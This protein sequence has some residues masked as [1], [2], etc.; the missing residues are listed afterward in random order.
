M[1]SKQPAPLTSIDPPS[2]T[3]PGL[4]RGNLRNL[5]ATG[6]RHHPFSLRILVSPGVEYPI[7]VGKGMSDK[8]QFVVLGHERFLLRGGEK[9]RFVRHNEVWTIVSNPRIDRRYGGSGFSRRREGA[10]ARTELSVSSSSTRDSQSHLAPVPPSSREKPLDSRDPVGPRFR[11]L[12]PGKP[13]RRV[14]SPLGRHVIAKFGGGGHGRYLLEAGSINGTRVEY[15]NRSADLGGRASS[16]V[17]LQSYRCHSQQQA[18]LP[19][20]R[21][22]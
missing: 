14:T 22:L 8:L 7:I 18:V 11:I 6:E 17:F 9:L 1:V 13:R 5:P 21:K 20:L 15:R 3:I 19:C 4:K 10:A 2:I 16:A 12:G